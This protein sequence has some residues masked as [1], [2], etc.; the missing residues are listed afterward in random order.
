MAAC[1]FTVDAGPGKI[2]RWQVPARRGH[3]DLLVSAALIGALDDRS[4]RPRAAV[5]RT[6]VDW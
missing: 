6:R 2:L 5:G 4:W 3:D 1:T